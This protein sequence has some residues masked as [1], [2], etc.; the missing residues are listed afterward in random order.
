[1]FN[2]FISSICMLIFLVFSGLKTWNN[3]RIAE[4]REH[5][6]LTG[7]GWRGRGKRD[8]RVSS[9]RYHKR[10]ANRLSLPCCPRIY[11]DGSSSQAALIT[12]A[13][14]EGRNSK[15]I[16][17]RMARPV[18]VFQRFTASGTT[19][20]S[21]RQ[22]LPACLPAFLPPKSHDRAREGSPGA[23]CVILAQIQTIDRWPRTVKRSTDVR[24]VINMGPMPWMDLWL[25]R[26][27][28]N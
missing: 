27:A 20:I 9:G 6:I 15:R 18:A 3:V 17:D 8:C 23:L 28:E 10:A 14:L 2:A 1:L 26:L 25:K 19:S 13:Q 16:I 22:S 21:L 12:L 7:R 4:S 11:R 5:E 24:S